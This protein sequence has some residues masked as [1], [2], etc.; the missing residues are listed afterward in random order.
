MAASRTTL[1]KAGGVALRKVRNQS[2]SFS[3]LL[4]I[5]RGGFRAREYLGK[6][7]LLTG[8]RD[9][10]AHKVKLAKMIATQRATELRDEMYGLKSVTKRKSDFM[11]F[12]ANL[13][14]EKTT[15]SK[16]DE[17][18]KTDKRRRGKAWINTYK[19]LKAYLRGKPIAFAAISSEFV[20]GFRDYLL[21]ELKPNSAR[22]Y[23]GNFVAAL[24]IAVQRKII[25]RN[26]ADTVK[27]IPSHETVRDF[28]TR[29][30][31]QLL[32]ET[33][34]EI[35]EVKKAFLF[36]CYCG[37]RL[38][39]V[40]AL[41]W[42]QVRPEGVQLIQR[43]TKNPIYLPLN[44]SARRYLGKRANS[45]DKVFDL[46]ENDE[47]IRRHLKKWVKKAGIDKN[48]SFHNSRHTFGT[49]LVSA[50]V[51]IYTIQKLL[52]H[53]KLEHTEIYAK[54]VSSVKQDAVDKLDK[55]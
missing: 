35:D 37:L 2:G 51:S 47:R 20:T 7:F 28:L 49:L 52:G 45:R 54:M 43:K 1:I 23:Y 30:E 6:D 50:D 40:K 4:D 22:T 34:C 10:D 24:N 27:G 3:L 46:P 14:I 55:I 12:F 26:P 5:N 41:M 32:D 15:E 29:Q 8:D 19:K 21:R 36:C 18:L 53:T 38:S 9:A 31:L 13:L 11:A 44:A 33:P 48:I 16:V 39:D 42:S 17:S 25:I